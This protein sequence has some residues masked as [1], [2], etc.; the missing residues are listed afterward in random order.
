VLPNE[1]IDVIL[2]MLKEKK[3]VRIAEISKR[4]DVSNLTA[5][6][7]LDVLQ[8][9]KIVRR[10]YGGAILIADPSK[11]RTSSSTPSL[12]PSA[13]NELHSIGKAAASMIQ[14]GDV[15]F[16]GTGSAILEVARNMHHL[17]DVT[18]ITNSL[19]VI[20]ELSR[21]SNTIRTVGG[22]LDNNEQ[23]IYGS[24]ANDLLKTFCADKAFI[25]CGGVS[26]THGVTDYQEPLADICRIM[27][28]NSAF[29]VL[30]CSSNKFDVNAFSI[31]C[32]LSKLNAI[33][34]DDGI[35][36]NAR[37]QLEMESLDLK[38]VE[39]EIQAQQI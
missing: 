17:S 37:R 30:V 6:R 23:F 25:G 1:R 34:T 38:I 18:V 33:I 21:T 19:A 9:R 28:H 12:P 32:P 39:R 36:Q 10:V 14:E 29:S 22:T 16:L 26:L 8:D 3:T 20:N 35:P 7:D 2:D 31:V 4:F 27:V 15:V 11:L 24:S 13:Y 5:R